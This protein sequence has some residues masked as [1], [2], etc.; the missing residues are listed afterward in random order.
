LYH[1]TKYEQKSLSIV[2]R[3]TVQNWDVDATTGYVHLEQ[4]L[5]IK[6]VFHPVVNETGLEQPVPFQRSC[7][8]EVM[9]H[10]PCIPPHSDF[11]HFTGSK[12]PWLRG[13]P[14]NL[15]TVSSATSPWHFWFAT[16]SVLN[17][18]MQMGLDFQNWR[19]HHRPTLGMFPTQNEAAL[20][21]YVATTT[22]ASTDPNLASETVS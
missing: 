10:K 20:T 5:D 22:A 14:D 7:W 12:K 21:T 9:A 2:L 4:T 11:V 3:N 18:K 8:K 13:P 1:Y 16:L 19:A 15:V 17:D 6:S